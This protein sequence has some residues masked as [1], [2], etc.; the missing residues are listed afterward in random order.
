M[1]LG[2]KSIIIF[3]FQFLFFISYSLNDKETFSTKKVSLSFKQTK[4]IKQDY[5]IVL[6]LYKENNFPL[7]L[8]KGLEFLKKYSKVNSNIDGEKYLYDIYFILGEVYRK[9]NSQE[10]SLFFLKKAL[11]I[12]EKD[13][14][15]ILENK[16]IILENKNLGTLYL[17]IGNSFISIGK[18]DS[19]KYY[20][21]KILELNS[22]NKKYLS[23]KASAIF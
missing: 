8:E 23:A 13:S 22:L 2:L 14:F 11:H 9:T 12:L 5:E 3:I 18:Q 10:N 16:K 4:S 20:Y 1:N 21:N 17:K 7:T 15:S 6:K 19:A